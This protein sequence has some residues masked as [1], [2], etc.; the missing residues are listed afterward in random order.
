M[1]KIKCPNCNEQK[2]S[3]LLCWVCGKIGFKCPECKHSLKIKNIGPFL[4]KRSSFIIG[5]VLGLAIVIIRE[6]SLDQ[7]NTILYILM[8]ISLTLICD[9][10]LD[11]VKINR[12]ILLIESKK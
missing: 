1:K 9:F 10:V 3:F 7:I 2:I 6:V 4:W 5:G 8:A 12:K 11:K